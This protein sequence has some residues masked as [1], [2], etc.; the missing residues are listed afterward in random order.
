MD[1]RG[2]SAEAMPEPVK[3]KELKVHERAMR[4]FVNLFF[5]PI[6]WLLHFSAI[7][8]VQSV[9]CA[10][11]SAIHSVPLAIIIIT[12]LALVILAIPMLRSGERYDGH[13]TSRF[14]GRTMRVL[15]LLSA[16]AIVWGCVAALLLHPCAPLR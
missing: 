15:S 10:L 14:V 8:A 6:I 11:A 12:A 1:F 3:R 9:F 7:Y 4:D 5:G 2:L 16:V 13:S